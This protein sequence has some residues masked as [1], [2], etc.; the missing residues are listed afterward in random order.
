MSDQ[1]QLRRELDEY[2]AR[3][4]DKE[5]KVFELLTSAGK[6]AK[7]KITFDLCGFEL[8]TYSSIPK[9]VR[10]K[11]IEEISRLSEEVKEDSTNIKSMTD[12]CAWFMSE[13]C[14]D[15]ELKHPEVWVQYDEECGCLQSVA[16][17]IFEELSVSSAELKRVRKH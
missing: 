12:V 14:Y 9:G 13:I 1:E 16:K 10:E 3:K 4:N 2:R 5:G 7:S 8:N 11:F 6:V 15:E 17:E